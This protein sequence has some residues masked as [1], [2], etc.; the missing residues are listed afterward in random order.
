MG[1]YL[2][3]ERAGRVKIKPPQVESLVSP[4]KVG[5]RGLEA[6]TAPEERKI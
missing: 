5:S 6:A 2:I 4:S 1:A 3:I